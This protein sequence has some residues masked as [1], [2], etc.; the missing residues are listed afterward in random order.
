MGEPHR[1]RNSRAKANGAGISENRVILWARGRASGRSWCKVEK[2][3]RLR[4]SLAG[5]AESPRMGTGSDPLRQ[6]SGVTKERR[7]EG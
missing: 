2:A 3:K 1:F 6:S 4:L 7:N 5:Q